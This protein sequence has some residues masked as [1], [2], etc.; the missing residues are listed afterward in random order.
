M[1][2]VHLLSYWTLALVHSLPPRLDAMSTFDLVSLNALTREI[3]G[4]KTQNYSSTKIL[5][6]YRC[7]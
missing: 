2:K 6:E 1:P 7:R 4:E 5:C 3:L